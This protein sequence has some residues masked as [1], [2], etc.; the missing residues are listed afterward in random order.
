MTGLH[1][2][3]DFGVDTVVRDLLSSNNPD[4]KDSHSRTPLSWAAEYGNEAVVQ[5]LL[6]KGADM[7]VE[8]RSGYTALQIAVF[9]NHER[10]RAAIG[11]T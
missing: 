4:L 1:L 6:R 5:L 9:N 3:T 8:N 2:A 10:S 11:N 7:R